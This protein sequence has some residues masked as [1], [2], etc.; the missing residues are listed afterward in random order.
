MIPYSEREQ[1]VKRRKAGEKLI[2]LAKELGYSYSGVRK[3]WRLYRLDGMV[4]IRPKYA[5]CGRPKRGQSDLIYRAAC[6]LKYL[7]RKWGADFIKQVLEGR[8]P[9]LAVPHERTLQRW[10]RSKGY[11]RIVFRRLPAKAQTRANKV[12]GTWQVDAKERFQ[13][14]SGQS[15]CYLNITDEYS[16]GF[17]SLQ[18]FPPQPY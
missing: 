13:L 15:A 7:H 8:Y 10:F 3:I 17:I 9:H 14:A 5:N 2:D 6:W 12:H 18:H 16:G 11:N 1:I 4:G